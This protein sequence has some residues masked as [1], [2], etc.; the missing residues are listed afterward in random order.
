MKNNTCPKCNEKIS[1][2]YMKET[3][4]HCKVNLLYYNLDE[5][6][7]ADAE[8]AQKEVDAVNKFVNIIKSSSIASPVLIV[9]L[10]LFFTPLA[11]MCLPMYGD[12]SLISLI[13]GIVNG[14]VEI[15]SVIMPLISMALVVVLS[16]A[17]IISSLFSSTKT[18]LLRNMIFSAVNTIVFVA[19]GVI[20]GGMGVGWYVTLVIYAIE[21]VLHPICNRVVKEKINN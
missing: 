21:I 2:F 10:V 16:L 19:L 14:S 6:L 18:G 5:R 11:S 12:I 8:Q 1:P 15:S 17:V 20:I 4:P 3:C 7:K 13:M 9:R